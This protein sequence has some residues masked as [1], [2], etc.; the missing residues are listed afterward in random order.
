MWCYCW[1]CVLM[2][3]CYLWKTDLLKYLAEVVISH[4]TIGLAPRDNLQL[5]AGKYY[6]LA[7]TL[8]ISFVLAPYGFPKRNLSVGQCPVYLKQKKNNSLGF[9]Q[10][11]IIFSATQILEFVHLYSF[12]NK[13]LNTTFQKMN[14]T[15]TQKLKMNRAQ[16]RIFLPT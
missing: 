12:K 6:I 13:I 7:N 14:S 16:I 10:W 5:W 9:W 8:I 15:L 2:V 1:F 11:Y 3:G 4:G